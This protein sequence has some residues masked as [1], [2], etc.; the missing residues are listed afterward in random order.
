MVKPVIIFFFAWAYAA[1]AAA[2]PEQQPTPPVWGTLPE[3]LAEAAASGGPVL[4]YVRADWC[5]P[6]RRLERETY[7]DPAV[8]RR[9]SRFAL[10]RLTFDDHERHQRLGPYRLS[11]AA[12]AARLGADA[13]PTLVFL[14]PD[15]AVLGRHTGFLPPAG[16]LPLLDAALADV[17]S[18]YASSR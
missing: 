7:V 3:A 15:G 17:E 13:T 16:L 6:C 1:T 4:V 10:A 5:G 2:Q 8:A 14:A 11:E 9:L 12:W 18:E